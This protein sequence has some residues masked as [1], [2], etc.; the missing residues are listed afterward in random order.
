[1]TQWAAVG[2]TRDPVLSRDGTLGH[3]QPRTRIARI[4]RLGLSHAQRSTI[5]GTVTKRDRPTEAVDASIGYGGPAVRG[6][7]SSEPSANSGAPDLSGGLKGCVRT[8]QSGGCLAVMDDLE[9]CLWAGARARS[10]VVRRGLA[11][12]GSSRASP[13]ELREPRAWGSGRLLSRSVRGRRH[14]ERPKN[15]TR[16]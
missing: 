9:G 2:A 4:A 12:E 8:I 10:L 11:P 5:P 16:A 7:L 6:R 1:V 15:A 13:L 14:D 3:V